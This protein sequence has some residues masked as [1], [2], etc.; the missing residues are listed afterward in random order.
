M[1]AANE[2]MAEDIMV[3]IG[4]ILR[5]AEPSTDPATQLIA[6]GKAM[7]NIGTELQGRT[8]SDARRIMRAVEAIMLP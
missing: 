6:V 5:V 2:L 3:K 7:V 8:L 1:K 4:D